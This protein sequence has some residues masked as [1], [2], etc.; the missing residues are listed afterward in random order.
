MEKTV[1]LEIKVNH[2][3]LVNTFRAAAG[4]LGIAFA[5][6]FP[7]LTARIARILVLPTIESHHDSIL[8]HSGTEI[9]S[10]FSAFKSATEDPA[11]V[12]HVFGPL[13]EADVSVVVQPFMDSCKD[14]LEARLV[15]NWDEYLKVIDFN[16]V[17]TQN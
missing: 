4:A 9:K 6:D 3:A 5:M 16:S 15:C 11:E 2:N 13:L 14:L 8:K 10:L 17:I 1:D 7:A 12:V